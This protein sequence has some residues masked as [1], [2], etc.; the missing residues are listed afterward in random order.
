[1]IWIVVGVG[2]L[3]LIVIIEL[4]NEVD[5]QGIFVVVDGGIKFFGDF[6]K[7]IVVGV[8]F[9]MVGLLLVG[10][11]ESLGEVYFYQG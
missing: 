7:V 1:M 8:F 3:Q 11:E 10:M 6:V 2:V 9:V 4:V 5:K